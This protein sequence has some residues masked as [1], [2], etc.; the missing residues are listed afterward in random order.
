M[1]RAMKQRVKQDKGL[2]SDGGFRDVPSEEE[3]LSKVQKEVEG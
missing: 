3:I 1:L 2:E